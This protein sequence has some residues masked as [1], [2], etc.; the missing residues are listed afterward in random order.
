M[1][2]NLT[3]HD[4]KQATVSAEV[5]GDLAI[6]ESPVLRQM[7]DAGEL[8]ASERRWVVTQVSTGMKVCNCK[9]DNDARALV[10]EL[11]G[12]PAWRAYITSFESGALD[13]EAQ[14]VVSAIVRRYADRR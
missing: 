13:A 4:G 5:Y 11:N 14:R 9:T 12:E 7:I 6:H 10:R 2:I 8:P 3:L 1:N